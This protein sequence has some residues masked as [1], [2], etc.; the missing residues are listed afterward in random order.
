MKQDIEKSWIEKFDENYDVLSSEI[1]ESPIYIAL[2]D[3]GEKLWASF[4]DT[5]LIN[6]IVIKPADAFGGSL[7]IYLE[8]MSDSYFLRLWF[9]TTNGSYVAGIFKIVVGPIAQLIPETFSQNG[10]FYLNDLDTFID[11]F[12]VI[13]AKD[14][15]N[16][17][18]T[19]T[20]E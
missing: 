10:L 5:K 2:R 13:L 6:K 15:M 3:F 14:K 7:Q 20:W 4:K 8:S 19:S 17:I 11:H 18:Q 16:N 1:N 12:V 9:D